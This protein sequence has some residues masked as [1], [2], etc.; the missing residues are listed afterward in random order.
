MNVWPMMALHNFMFTSLPVGGLPISQDR[1]GIKKPVRK[2]IVHTLLRSGKNIQRN[3]ALKLSVRYA[4][5][6]LTQVKSTADFSMESGFPL[7]L[8][9]TLAQ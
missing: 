6:I 3:K 5:L 7:P 8:M 1:P 4:I 2:R 9:A